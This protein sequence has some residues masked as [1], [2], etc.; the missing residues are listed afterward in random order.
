MKA[1]SFVLSTLL[2]SVGLLITP[3]AKA[4]NGAFAPYVDIG[5]A[6]AGSD[7][8]LVSTEAIGNVGAGIE[9]SSKHLLLDVNGQ[10][11]SANGFTTASG[12]TDSVNGSGYLKAGAFLLGGGASYSNQIVGVPTTFGNL[13]TGFVTTV[14]HINVTQVRPFIGAGLQLPRDRVIV[15]Y[16]LPGSDPSGL[17]GGPAF[18]VHNEIFLSNH[19][20]FDHIRFVQNLDFVNNTTGTTWIVG[21]GLKFVL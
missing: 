2:L 14:E 8:V 15:N 9:S 16:F 20:L 17:A 5:I 11:T 13:A 12:Y 18:Q 7:S 3:A 6:V 4:Q 10:F 19:G 1:I 21:G